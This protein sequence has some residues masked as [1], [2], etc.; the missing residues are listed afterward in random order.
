MDSKCVSAFYAVYSTY[1]VYGALFQGIAL[2]MLSIVSIDRVY[3]ARVSMLSKQ[4]SV[5]A[6]YGLP[7]SRV[8]DYLYCL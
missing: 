5:Y 3:T 6:V 1:T 7:Y 4:S 8:L 2:S